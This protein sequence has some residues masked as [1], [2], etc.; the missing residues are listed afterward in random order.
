M[1]CANLTEALRHVRTSESNAAMTNNSPN[2]SEDTDKELTEREFGLRATEASVRREELTVRRIE[3]EKGKLAATAAWWKN[4]NPLLIAISAGVVTL[5]GDVYVAYY[6]GYTSRE[7]ERLRAD[8]ALTVEK[9]KSKASLIIQAMGTNNDEKALANIRFFIAAELLPD[10][11]GKILAAAMR[12]KPSLPAAME[13][14]SF[15]AG[16]NLPTALQ[17]R[18]TNTASD[19]LNYFKLLG[20][21]PKSPTVNVRIFKPGDVPDTVAYYDGLHNTI[22]VSSEVAK[23]DYVI[24]REYSHR[25]LY[26]SLN[27]DTLTSSTK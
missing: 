9:E 1:L 20:Y 18:L 19:Y 7:Q 15:D 25:I 16:A 21:I 11:D 10:K 22:A 26:S 23:N 12:F 24:L 2:R 4:P 5:A 8:A 6:N 13:S 14:L 27:F 3:A 17:E